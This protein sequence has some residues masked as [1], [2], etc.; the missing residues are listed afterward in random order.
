MKV[1]DICSIGTLNSHDGS[2]NLS[3]CFHRGGGHPTFVNVSKEASDKC[4]GDQELLKQLFIDTYKKTGSIK[5][6]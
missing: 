2:I 4:K 1:K 5:L 6:Y 3:A